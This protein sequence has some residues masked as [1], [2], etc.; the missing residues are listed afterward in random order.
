MSA[1][2]AFDFA[3]NDPDNGDFA[4]RAA[5]VTYRD[6]EL[7]APNFDVGYR[8]ADSSKTIRIHRRTFSITGRRDWIGNWCWNRYYLPRFEAKRLLLTLRSQGWRSVGGPVRL[9]DWWD[10]S[11]AA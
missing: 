3:C 4:G 9:C 8:F 1:I 7:E 10:R 2:R 5:L 6:L 11:L